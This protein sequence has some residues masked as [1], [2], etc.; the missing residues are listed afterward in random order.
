MA[1]WK[2]RFR[3]AVMVTQLTNWTKYQVPLALAL[4]VLAATPRFFARKIPSLQT[5]GPRPTTARG[6]NSGNPHGIPRGARDAVVTDKKGT[7]STISVKRISR[8]TKTISSKL[9]QL[10]LRNDPSGPLNAQKHYMIL[11][12]EQFLH[13]GP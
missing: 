2:F 10:F 9:S 1:A 7:T 8:S 13:G 5:R 12:F 6:H 11:F 3:E 4:L